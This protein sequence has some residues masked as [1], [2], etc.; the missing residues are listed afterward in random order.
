[1]N[2]LILGGGGREHTFAWKIKQSPLCENLYVAPGN[3]GTAQIAQNADL[4]LFDFEEVKEFVISNDIHLL[5]VG[6]EAPLVAGISDFFAEQLPRL[7][8]IGPKKSAARLEGS[9]AFAK[10]F[11]QEYKIPTA[12]YIEVNAENI[13]DG[14]DYLKNNNGPYVLKADGLA[15]GKGVLIIDGRSEAI[16]ELKSM[17]DGKFGEASK[18]VVIEEFLTGIEFSVFVMT[19]GKYYILLPEA[20][21]YKRI[22]IGDTGLN[23]G[24]MGAIS[25][26]PFVD[27]KMVQKVRDRIILPTLSGLQDRQL[28]YVGFIFFGLISVAGEPY[29][30]EYNCRMGDP[31]TEVILPR[32]KNDFLELCES[33]FERDLYEI[34]LDKDPRT[35][36]TVMTVSEGYPGAYVKGREI[37]INVGPESESLVFHAGTKLESE[38]VVTNGGRVIAVTSLDDNMRTAIE[39]SMETIKSIDF[40]GKYYRQDIGFDL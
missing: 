20:K 23:T 32:V 38:K 24:G 30:I 11:M 31:E 17:L 35:A 5:L 28:E 36:A 15:A 2:V 13:S 14:I 26:V 29:V 37:K 3:A 40:Q 18:K 1:M 33:L 6:P 25:P 10:S 34:G 21:D 19:D 16:E 9:K 39:K 27:Q 4:D 8:V 7:M 12:G 22:G